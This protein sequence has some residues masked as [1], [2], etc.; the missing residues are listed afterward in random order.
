M[1][2]KSAEILPVFVMEPSKIDTL[3]T[4]MPRAEV[5]TEIVPALLILPANVET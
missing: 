5:A 1:V 4:K 3:L 2:L